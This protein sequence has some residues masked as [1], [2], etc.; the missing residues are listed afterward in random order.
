LN[1]TLIEVKSSLKLPS[2]ECSSF[3]L[4]TSLLCSVDIFFN[5]QSHSHGYD[6][7]S[8]H[9]FTSLIMEIRFHTRFFQDKQNET[10]SLF[11]FTFCFIDI[12]RLDL[13][14]YRGSCEGYW[15]LSS[16]SAI[17]GISAYNTKWPVKVLTFGRRLETSTLHILHCPYCQILSVCQ[18][19]KQT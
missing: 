12:L 14:L 17:S 13:F 19:M 3:L 6:M 15:Y 5:R 7:S 2:S 1:A 18:D 10:S 4:T 11:Q 8:S 16:L 9:G